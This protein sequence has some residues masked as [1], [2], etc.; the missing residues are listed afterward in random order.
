MFSF[1][2]SVVT[3]I[4]LDT[5]SS[6]PRPSHSIQ[7]RNLPPE[8]IEPFQEGITRTVS[9]ATLFPSVLI[10]SSSADDFFVCGG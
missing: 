8:P 10:C 1:L 3:M 2:T 5:L 7:Q 6:N 9:P 4:S